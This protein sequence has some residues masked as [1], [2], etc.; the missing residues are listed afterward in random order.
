MK[1]FNCFVIHLNTDREKVKIRNEA[2]KMNVLLVTKRH[3][4]VESCVFWRVCTTT[5]SVYTFNVSWLG[6]VTNT[7]REPLTTAD[8]TANVTTADVLGYGL[9]YGLGHGLGFRGL[10]MD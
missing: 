7:R 8:S 1:L 2:E 5:H 9:W 3:F 4:C 10:G 6:L